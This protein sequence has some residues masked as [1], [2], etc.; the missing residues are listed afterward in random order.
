MQLSR[1]SD[2]ELKEH[3]DSFTTEFGGNRIELKVIGDDEPNNGR[4][5]HIVT[6][7]INGKDVTNEYLGDWNRTY[8]GLGNLNFSD[9]LNRFCFIPLESKPILIN[10]KTLQ[11]INVG[12]FGYLGNSF[13]NNF[14]LLFGRNEI[15]ITDLTT[16]KTK[17][18]EINDDGGI[19]Y[20]YFINSKRIRVIHYFS[21]YTSIIDSVTNK[22][23]QRTQIK[24]DEKYIKTFRWI[25][26]SHK[27]ISDDHNE[28]QLTWVGGDDKKLRES[29]LWKE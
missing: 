27:Q 24:V 15:L 2:I 21:N 5:L 26:W 10:V 9:S 22:T 16:Y 4:M 20:A 23:I 18:L 1:L 6:L 11:I 3:S 12:P 8:Y 13:F 28:L 17:S 25:V 7:T 14:H 29:Y 19:E